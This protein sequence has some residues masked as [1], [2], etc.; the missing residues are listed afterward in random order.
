MSTNNGWGTGTQLLFILGGVLLLVLAWVGGRMTAGVG[1]FDMMGDGMHEMRMGQGNHGPGGGAHRGRAETNRTRPGDG[2]AGGEFDGDTGLK[3]CRAMMG[4][5]TG[6]HRSMQSMMGGANEDTADRRGRM[7]RGMM[8]GRMGD[9]HAD[10][11]RRGRMRSMHDR[12][13]ARMNAMDPEQMRGLCRTMHE[14]MQAAM[15]GDDVA[16]AGEVD[17]T[18]FEGISLTDKTEQW[19]Q[20]ARGFQTV[21]DRTGQAEVVVDVGTGDGLQYGP[22]AVRVD[23]GTTVRWRWTGQGGLHNVAFVNAEITTSLKGDEGA[24]FEYTFDVAGEYRY[25]CTP[26]AGVGMRG[27]ILVAEKGGA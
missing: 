13:G 3:R 16:S 4:T 11:D 8:G 9:M 15:H 24:T 1:P 21:Q 18:T 6:M 23:P 22:V 20:G 5:M 10:Q 14:A 25:E 26:H 27:A 7:G 2:A 19:L 17:E 12:M